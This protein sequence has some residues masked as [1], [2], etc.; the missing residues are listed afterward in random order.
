MKRDPHL[1][2]F[3]SWQSVTCEMPK[4]E[5]IWPKLTRWNNIGRDCSK[6]T[7]RSSADLYNLAIRRFSVSMKARWCNILDQFANFSA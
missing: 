2:L 5:A 4:K 1:T 6:S 7:Y 3:L